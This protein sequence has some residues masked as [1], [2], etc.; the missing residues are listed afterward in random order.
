M[1][2]IRDFRLLRELYVA[3]STKPEPTEADKQCR[4]CFVASRSELVAVAVSSVGAVVCFRCGG[5]SC[6]RFLSSFKRTRP[7][8]SVRPPSINSSYIP[9]CVA[10][11]DGYVLKCREML[12][13]CYP[14]CLWK[15]LDSGTSAHRFFN[16][17]STY[18]S[19]NLI[20]HHHAL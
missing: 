6:F 17:H 4:T 19:G 18:Y 7:D 2:K 8:A 9:R 15:H 10:L 13:T 5:I 20:T 1:C 3:N 12:S 14:V 11:A 16:V